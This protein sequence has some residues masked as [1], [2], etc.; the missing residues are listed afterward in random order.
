FFFFSSRRRH[1]RCYR[2]WSS[3]VCSSD[4]IQGVVLTP[5]CNKDVRIDSCSHRPRSSRTHR[6]T[7]FRPRE[8]PGVPIPRYFSNGLLVL[9]GRSE[10]RRVGKE[11]ML[12]G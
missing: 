11:C 5:E 8:I 1:T 12:W 3:D 6:R 2:D 4:L 9:T 7:A 10:E